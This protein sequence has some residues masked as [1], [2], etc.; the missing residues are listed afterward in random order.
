MAEGIARNVVCAGQRTG[1]DNKTHVVLH[2]L[3]AENKLNETERWYKYSKGMPSIIGGIYTGASFDGG[4]AHGLAAVR[5]VGPW[6]GDPVLVAAWRAAEFAHDLRL[7]SARNEKKHT[8]DLAA[9]LLPLRRTL[10][11]MHKRGMHME[12]YNYVEMIAAE[13]RRPLRKTELED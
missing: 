5:Y 1:K 8:D 2:L 13:M 11:A 10:H 3:E 4:T 6:D 9:T 12:A 7:A